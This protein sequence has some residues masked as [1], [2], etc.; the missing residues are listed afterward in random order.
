MR[1]LRDEGKFAQGKIAF[2]QYLSVGIFL[3]IVAGYWNLQIRNEEIYSLKAERN[4]IKAL[5]VPAPRGK[6]LDRDKRVIVDNHSSFSVL[7]SLET[8][9]E[10]HIR[11]IA[12]GLDLDYD[13]V[14]ASLKARR[15]RPKYFPITLKQELT[16]AEIAFVE[17][18]RDPGT[19]RSTRSVCR[20]SY[21]LRPRPSLPRRNH[22]FAQG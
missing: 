13:E 11:P 6:I 18:H 10:E 5:P 19:F 8:L 7:L 21:R 20:L 3:F 15:S 1:F 12:E 17:S 14:V 9:K 16:P 22:S 4:R 2:L